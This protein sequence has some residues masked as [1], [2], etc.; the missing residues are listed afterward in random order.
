MASCS[1]GAGSAA[2]RVGAR[3]AA[4]GV[5]RFQPAHQLIVAQAAG[6]FLDVRFQV[7]DGVGVLGVA[8]ARQLRQ[9][10]DQRLAVAR[11][12]PRHPAGQVGVQRAVAG[13]VALVQ[14][15]DVQLGVGR[16]GPRRTPRACAPSGS[17]AGR[18]P[19]AAAGRRRWPL[20]WPGPR[21][22]PGTAAAGRYRNA[23]T[24]G[25]ARSRPPPAGPARREARETA[26]LAAASMTVRSTWAVRSASTVMASPVARKTFRVLE[27]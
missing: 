11:H 26:G 13:Q 5:D 20:C 17:C 15:A 2:A 25:A 21:A 8:V 16:R 4:G 3:G 6:R 19:T 10:A 27:G 18:H 24:G 22:R 14:Q 9:V 12:E 7:V 23:G 1:S